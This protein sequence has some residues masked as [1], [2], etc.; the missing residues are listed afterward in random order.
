MCVRRKGNFRELEEGA[1]LHAAENSR[2]DFSVCLQ[3]K[4]HDASR[5]EDPQHLYR[6]VSGLMLM[7]DCPMLVR[8]EQREWQ[9]RAE[10]LLSTLL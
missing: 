4:L 1:T 6:V 2:L 5:H 7:L 9:T 3:I 10:D 8:P